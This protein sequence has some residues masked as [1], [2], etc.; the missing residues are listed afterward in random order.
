MN[1]FSHLMEMSLCAGI[2]ILFILIL[3][4]TAQIRLPK[5]IFLLL[6]D[7]VIIRL[8]F[9]FTIP[10]NISW[11]SVFNSLLL[12]QESPAAKSSFTSLI[13]HEVINAVSVHYGKI[14]VVV[15]WVI[16]VVFCTSFFLY[17]YYNS[18]KKIRESLPLKNK[19]PINHILEGLPLKRN[20]ILQVS[21]QI[22][23][24]ITY[25]LFKPRIVLPIFISTEYTIQLKHIITHEYIH[26]KRF[27]CIQ[28]W[29]SILAVCVHWFNPLVWLMYFKFND[30]LEI[31]CDMQVIKLLGEQ[32]KGTYASSLIKL[33]QQQSHFFNLY[34][35]FGKSA[36][37]ERIVL[38]MKYKKSTAFGIGCA[39][40][41]FIV[42][43]TVFASTSNMGKETSSLAETTKSSSKK[44]DNPKS[45][46]ESIAESEK[47][48]KTITDNSKDSNVILPKKQ[49]GLSEANSAVPD[50][51]SE[52]TS[53]TELQESDASKLI[54]DTGN[55]SVLLEE[56]ETENA[57][58]GSN[59]IKKSLN[60]KEEENTDNTKLIKT[61]ET[62]NDSCN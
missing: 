2:L 11:L 32:E 36:V 48:K 40:L 37:K 22:T 38:I 19:E 1:L 61:I 12:K 31:M 33:A 52:D 58:K 26:I 51:I 46:D 10:A 62:T 54:K 60:E 14:I 43:T 55:N 56:T 50:S 53:D 7:I 23:T 15:I 42:S 27:D 24:P 16:G 20:I 59:R 28:K 57:V 8:L 41:L 13:K 35:G 44:A 17:Q 18:Y 39:V 29:L 49:S 4:K 30:D 34:Q 47:N 25:G 5:T 21:D 9:P 45:A 3:R 6:W